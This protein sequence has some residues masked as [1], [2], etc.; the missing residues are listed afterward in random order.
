MA[1]ALDLI[2]SSMRLIGVLAS[3]E[4]LSANEAT[5]AL[6]TLNDM[7]GIWSNESL[8]I[9]ARTNES[10]TLTPNQ[11]SYTM[12]SGGNFNT[13]RPQKIENASIT[14]S[15]GS[16]SYDVPVELTNQDE[17]AEIQVKGI[18]SGIPTRLFPL[19][20][21]PLATIYLWPLPNAANKLTLWSWKTLSN[22]PAI[23][24]AVDL[25]PGYSKAMKYNLALELAPEYGR[26]VDP[27]VLAEASESKAALKR[28][29]ARPQYL[30][31]D[32]AV[33]APRA[34]FNWL[35]GE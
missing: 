11:Q 2:N 24:T 12:G 34:G 3:G 6:S 9:Y 35:T 26:P 19:Y 23:S 20:T 1:K 27:I 22:I 18:S 4:T 5:D 31:M 21:Y 29:N 13:T 33:L 10:F 15:N 25:P 28:M 16:E 7:L 17:W 30:A 32:E 8:L 14:I